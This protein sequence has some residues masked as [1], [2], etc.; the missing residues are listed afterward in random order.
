MGY[1]FAYEIWSALDQIYASSS[2]A[3]VSEINTQLQNLKKEGMTAMDYIQKL[4]TLCNTLTSIG[5]TVSRKDHLFYMVNGLD[6][7]YNLF[8]ASINNRPNLPSIE[9]IHSLFLSY[10]FFLEQQHAIPSLNNVQA[11]VALLQN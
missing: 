2:M 6:K 11:N 10:E 1:N 9:E 7:E 4:K 5:E 8:V 3:W